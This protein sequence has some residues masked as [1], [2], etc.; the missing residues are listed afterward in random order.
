MTNSF[1]GD[2]LTWFDDHGR[3]D[4][5]W[6]QDTSPYR[7]WLSE[8][9]LQ[10]TQVSTVV[11]YFRRFTERYANV[12]Q[13]AGAPLDA[14]L[15]LWTGLGYYARARNLHKTARIVTDEHGGRF[16]ASVEA[17]SALPGI[18]RSTAGAIVAIAHGQRAVIL[19][20]NVKRVLSRYHAV[21]GWPGRAPITARLWQHADQ[22]TP[23]SRIADYTQ[24]IMD[25]GA[26]LCTR[27]KPRCEEC[28]LQTACQAS[29]QGN[30]LD[31]PGKKP[32]KSLPV[33]S[34][35]FLV[36]SNP[37]G[38]VLLTQ[39]PATGLW[40][41]LWTFPQCD[42]EADIARACAQAGCHALEWY[43]DPPRRHSF[44][45]YHLDYTPV[46]IRVEPHSRVGETSGIWYNPRKPATLGLPAPVAALLAE[47][48]G[49][50]TPELD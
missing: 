18:G 29:Q 40:G 50:A 16:P 5:P 32:G 15:H 2:L 17:L 1:A 48:A 4:L 21:E 43:M 46:R 20:G 33:R 49:S 25:L 10:Q 6:Q 14:V 34:S 27:S 28:P 31:Y 35:M 19:D 11:P 42:P 12:R 41:G 13:L 22:H 37:A 47:R 7:V 36:M 39:R 3:K 45:H 8:I 23:A 38:E 26:T 30:P 9:M 44:S 24:A